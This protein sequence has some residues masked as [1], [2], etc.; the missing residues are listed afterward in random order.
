[1]KKGKDTSLG[2]ITVDCTAGLYGY[3]KIFTF[4]HL[5]FQEYL[6]AR[7]IS[8]LNVEEQKRLI[9]RHGD[10]AHMMVVWRF[11]SGLMKD[12]AVFQALLTHT[13]VN[14]RHII[15]CAYESQRPTTCNLVLKHSNCELGFKKPTYLTAP[16]FTALVLLSKWVF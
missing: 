9:V 3:T 13:V 5:T 16:D 1:M 15:Q 7:H 11:L 14:T 6:A 12:D 2:L 4:L 10:K 8:S